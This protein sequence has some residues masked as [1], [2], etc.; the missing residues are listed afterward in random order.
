M[1]TKVLDPVMMPEC[2]SIEGIETHSTCFFADL[3]RNSTEKLT[4]A[5]NKVSFHPVI[6]DLNSYFKNGK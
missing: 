2:Q 3:E 5:I 6:Y 4:Y 1:A